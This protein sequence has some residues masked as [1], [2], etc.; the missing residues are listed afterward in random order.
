M[1]RK[2]KRNAESRNIPIHSI[3]PTVPSFVVSLFHE[4]KRGLEAVFALFCGCLAI[5]CHHFDLHP[6]L[7]FHFINPSLIRI[8]QVRKAITYVETTLN[9]VSLFAN[10]DFIRPIEPRLRRTY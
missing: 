9:A 1:T 4:I 10:R 8:L 3:I 7:N 6:R 2:Y 5:H